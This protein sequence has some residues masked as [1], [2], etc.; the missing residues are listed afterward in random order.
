MSRLQ[1]SQI[2]SYEAREQLAPAIGCALVVLADTPETFSLC[3]PKQLM[4]SFEGVLTGV[5]YGQRKG[6]EHPL[7]PGLY[8]HF[9]TPKKRFR[10]LSVP[11]YRTYCL[12]GY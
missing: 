1:L 8:T 12:S 9:D 4:N 7:E 2:T 5:R 10:G 3:V 6:T 11:L